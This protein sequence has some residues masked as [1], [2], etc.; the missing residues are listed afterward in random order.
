MTND[1]FWQRIMI[2]GAMRVM[3]ALTLTGI[4]PGFEVAPRTRVDPMPA[5]VRLLPSSDRW[6][7]IGAGSVS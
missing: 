6:P 4:T 7:P 3:P 1:A 2:G 5:L